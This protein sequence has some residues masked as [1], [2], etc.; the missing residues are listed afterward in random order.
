[1]SKKK[2]K[3]VNKRKRRS[4]NTKKNQAM[5]EMERRVIVWDIIERIAFQPNS[6]QECSTWLGV[7]AKTLHKL[8]GVDPVQQHFSSSH[9]FDIPFLNMQ[10]DYNIES[11]EKYSI[12]LMNLSAGGNYWHCHI[13]PRYF[14]YTSLYSSSTHYP[15]QQLNELEKDVETVLDGMLFHPRC[16][17][18][19]DEIGVQS[20]QLDPDIG[21]LSSHEIRIGVGIEN[22]YVFLFHLRY[23]CCLVADPAR[24]EE[25]HR[26]I[27]LF[28]NSIKN[29]GQ[30][31][32]ARDLCNF[33]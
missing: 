20:I 3:A 2:R 15:H 5:S 21:G 29:K 10:C 24:Q 31:M 16:H 27:E 25:K 26:L 1:M 18:H 30:N 23:Q 32:S 14:S 22:P 4:M 6:D 7:Y 8:W 9:I 19:I 12:S 33:G 28:C 17:T 11:V 13:D